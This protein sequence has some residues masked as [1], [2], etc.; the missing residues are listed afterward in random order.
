MN[1]QLQLH[2]VQSE[3]G[4]S[5]VE[6]AL[7]LPMLLL[8]LLGVVD[9]GRA[10]YLGNE[11]AGAARA[12]AVYGSQF[13]MD[14]A[15]MTSAVNADAPDVSGISASPSYGCECSDGTSASASCSTVPSCTTNV[16][17]YVKVTASATYNTLFPWPGIPSSFP[18]SSTAEMRSGS[19]NTPF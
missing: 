4:S 9:F 10:F 8:L 3:Q 7:A 5:L 16:V 15:G 19:T 12:G 13:P 18:L 6:V 11:V 2:I 1:S 17:Y 14:T